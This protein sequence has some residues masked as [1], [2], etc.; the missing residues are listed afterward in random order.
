M[1]GLSARLASWRVSRFTTGFIASSGAVP[2][3]G[4]VARY[5]LTYCSVVGILQRLNLVN[6]PHRLPR[7][8]VYPQR[9]S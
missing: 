6:P 8:A 7:R 4:V 2:A 3:S 5:R 1:E 9:F